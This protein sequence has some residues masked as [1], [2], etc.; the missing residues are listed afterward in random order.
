M[1]RHNF[2]LFIFLFLSFSYL[3]SQSARVF[4]ID[5]FPTINPHTYT[6]PGLPLDKNW[7]YK[8]GDDSLWAK[9]DFDDS[10][11][12]TASTSLDLSELPAKTFEGIG[13]FRIHLSVDSSLL[14]KTLALMI[15]Q[16][17]AS[18]IYLDGKLIHT[19][20]KINPKNSSK[21]EHFNPLELPFE[22][23]FE[24]TSQVLAV[25]YANSSAM[26][27]H[28]KHINSTAGFDLKIGEIRSVT[29]FK[30]FGSVIFSVI[31]IFYFMTPRISHAPA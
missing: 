25:R 1:R 23:R 29:L 3:H 22:I 27:N 21:E 26:E 7:L 20:G 9:S 10:K 11:W 4:K 28:I 17:G 13:W 2:V 19:F 24:K 16:W 12:D 31:F 30:Y 6:N 18:E 14:N 8:K 15:L 5:S